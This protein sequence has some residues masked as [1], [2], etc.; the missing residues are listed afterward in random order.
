MNKDEYLEE[1]LKDLREQQKYLNYMK[2]YIVIDILLVVF[3]MFLFFMLL[4][5]IFK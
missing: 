5:L 3:E 2:E 4:V 1:L